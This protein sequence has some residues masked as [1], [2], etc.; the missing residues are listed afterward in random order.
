MRTFALTLQVLVILIALPA[1]AQNPA[2]NHDKAATAAQV[3][4]EV[5][6]I[7]K[8]G[9]F[10]QKKAAVARLMALA[11]QA[12][13]APV[14]AKAINKLR[15]YL[16]F[17]VSVATKLT[18][19]ID[20]AEAKEW[21]RRAARAEYERRKNAS[22]QLISLYVGFMIRAGL[23]ETALKLARGALPN[24]AQPGYVFGVLFD[25]GQK[26]FIEVVGRYAVDKRIPPVNRRI[27]VDY[28]GRWWTGPPCFAARIPFLLKA[29][30]SHDTVEEAKLGIWN[31]CLPNFKSGKRWKKWWDDMSDIADN[32]DDIIRRSFEDAYVRATTDPKKKDGA[33]RIGEYIEKWNSAHFKWALPL[34]HSMLLEFEDNELMVNVLYIIGKIKDPSSIDT[35]LKLIDMPRASTPDILAQVAKCLGTIS[36]AKSEQVGEAL[37]KLYGCLDTSVRRKVIESLGKI[38]YDTPKT[39]DL[40]V[41]IMKNPAV[42]RKNWAAA[43]ALGAMKALAA[44]PDM[45]DTIQTTKDNDLKLYLLRAFRKMGVK[46]SGIL[47]IAVVSLDE[48]DFR[49]QDAALKILTDIG[50][51]RAVPSI[52]RVFD[53]EKTPIKTRL[54]AL[55]ALAPYPARLVF[56]TFIEALKTRY[57]KRPRNNDE[58]TTSYPVVSLNKINKKAVAFF[59][60]DDFKN[61]IPEVFDLLIDLIKDARHNGRREA[62]QWVARPAIWQK[63]AFTVLIGL[64]DPK[65]DDKIVQQAVKGLIAHPDKEA[66][67]I[68]VNRLS[69]G[70][71]EYAHIDLQIASILCSYVALSNL[72][73]PE[74]PLGGFNGETDRRAWKDWWKK[75]KGKMR[76]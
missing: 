8:N 34:L 51:K 49:L 23:E 55:D 69:G 67:G 57:K 74:D 29:M 7:L 14:L 65:E 31:I 42:D 33:R 9:T 46:S 41:G 26:V 68:L 48:E 71:A 28:L 45:M 39:V 30:K 61:L 25:S 20:D 43:E 19:L 56:D 63:T 72:G 1:W 40:L 62:L 10:E 24:L 47:D 58:G 36:P 66:F 50:D 5:K 44:L 38:Q 12:G 6:P 27:A 52:C 60:K 4:A 70:H 64:L 73:D 59:E 76:F 32:D 22:S 3:W 21:V 35:V 75:N 37:H 18:E 13:L 11:P 2:A 54:L 16:E 53:N 17:Q 15:G